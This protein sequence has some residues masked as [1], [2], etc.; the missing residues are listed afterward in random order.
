MLSS[1]KPKA[2][3]KTISNVIDDKKNIMCLLESRL[4]ILNYVANHPYS[5]QEVECFASRKCS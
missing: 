3:S 2:T 4:E 1:M 5:Q